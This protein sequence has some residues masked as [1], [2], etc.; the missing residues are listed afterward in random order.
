M[1][2]IILLVF[3][4]VA[5]SLALETQAVAQSGDVLVANIVLG[6]VGDGKYFQSS[7]QLVNLA[8]IP[9][10]ATIHCFSN[11]GTL[12]PAFNL[13]STVLPPKQ[14]IELFTS[15]PG[16]FREC[17]CRIR[18][19]PGDRIEVSS[20]I[21]LYEPSTAVPWPLT[22]AMTASVRIPGSPQA[23]K[24]DVPVSLVRVAQCVLDASALS[25]VNPSE[26][27]AEVDLALDWHRSPNNAV[28]YGPVHLTIAPRS[29]IARSLTALFPEIAP[30]PELYPLPTR[31]QEQGVLTVTANLPVVVSGL[32]VSSP[33]IVYSSMLA[34]PES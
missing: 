4:S 14:V 23:P 17:W 25:V 30:K 32:E 2:R 6:D 24:W 7:I 19:N 20:R 31:A 27:A 8:D 13:D 12:T 34:I 9:S 11:D 33:K 29:R 16:A 3:I 1:G 21:S 10:E 22:S 18:P 26:T 15:G 5:V 28:Q